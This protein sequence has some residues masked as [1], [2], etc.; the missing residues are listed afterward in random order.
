MFVE[1]EKLIPKE[2]MMSISDTFEEE[3]EEKTSPRRYPGLL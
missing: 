2:K 3:Q 1:H